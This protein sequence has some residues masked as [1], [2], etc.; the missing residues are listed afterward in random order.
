MRLF[1]AVETL[2][3]F[4]R[5]EDWISLVDSSILRLSN[6]RLETEG[7]EGNQLFDVKLAARPSEIVI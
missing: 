7:G 4:V 1:E 2:S 3:C 6:Q 5:T